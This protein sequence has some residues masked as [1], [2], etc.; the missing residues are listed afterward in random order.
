[1]PLEEKAAT[2][3]D[4]EDV[5]VAA[6]GVQAE[7]EVAVAKLADFDVEEKEEAFGEEKT[8]GPGKRSGNERDRSEVD[9]ARRKDRD[10]QAERTGEKE[11]AHDGRG[12][13]AVVGFG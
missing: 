11:V 13:D 7:H 5:F 6:P 10:E 9:E 1:L 12:I 8:C 2:T 3:A 4:V